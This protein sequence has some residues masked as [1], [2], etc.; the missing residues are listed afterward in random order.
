[1]TVKRC[2]TCNQ[3]FTD[4]NLSFCIEDGTPLVPVDD[5]PDEVTVVSPSTSDGG[6][7]PAG[8]SSGSDEGTVPSYQPPGTYSAPRIPE[9]RRSV[10]PW[11][12]GL[13]LL[14]VLVIGGMGVAA[15]FYF[16]PLKRLS[17]NTNTAN[18]NT[19]VNQRDNS[20][21]SHSNS[22]SSDGNDNSDAATN[23][24][25]PTDEAVVLADLTK[26]EHEWTV[27]NIN[28][29]KKTLNRILADDYVGTPINGPPQGKAEY[30]T[31]IQRDTEIEK[32]EFD[33]L[34]VSLKGARATLT[35]TIRFKVQ[36]RDVP[37]RFV[38]KFVWRDGRWQA[39]GSEVKPLKQEGTP[40]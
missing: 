37:F 5:L 6:S 23:T 11:I 9:S 12:L 39:T 31:T 3:T 27:A 2:P 20:N 7:R 35:G 18:I 25:A 13:L 26:I 8:P 34:K 28:A 24:P 21:Q 29:D 30:L 33:D 17:A 4:R 16:Q 22:N 15:W 1:M 19:N 14:L 36:G 38:D 10:W 40:V 32:W